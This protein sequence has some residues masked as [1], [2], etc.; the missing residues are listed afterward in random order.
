MLMERGTLPSDLRQ[1]KIQMH[2]RQSQLTW[3][4]KKKK[5]KTVSLSPPSG[6]SKTHNKR[7]GRLLVVASL[8][9]LQ[10]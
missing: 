1:R 3:H 8:E 2:G 7:G 6:C 4:N 5:I 10:I 9:L